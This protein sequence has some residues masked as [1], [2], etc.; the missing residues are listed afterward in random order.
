MNFQ[1][2]ITNSKILLFIGFL[3]I[4]SLILPHITFAKSQTITL[5]Q[6]FQEAKGMGE[7]ALEILFYDLTGV[8]KGIW[9]KNVLPIWQ[10][11]YNFWRFNIWPKI[12][13]FFKKEVENPA[14]KEFEKRKPIIKEEFKK[15]KEELKKD[16]P[17]VSKSLWEKFK[18]LIK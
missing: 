11:I 13:G 15:E 9:K 12:H 14:K 1:F 16:I 10:K 5:P 17:K 6:T 7:N 18:E 4:F 8:L 2:S 3:I